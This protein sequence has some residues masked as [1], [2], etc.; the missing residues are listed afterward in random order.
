MGSTIRGI[1]VEMDSGRPAYAVAPEADAAPVLLL[2]RD[3]VHPL[4][5]EAVI[6]ERILGGL[7]RRSA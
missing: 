6:D 3:V 5:D 1:V 7:Q 4:A 2:R